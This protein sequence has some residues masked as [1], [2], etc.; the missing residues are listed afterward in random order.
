MINSVESEKQFIYSALPV[1][2][3]QRRLLSLIKR[4]LLYS[5]LSEIFE[6]STGTNR[7]EKELIEL[8]EELVDDETKSPENSEGTQ[9]K[10]KILKQSSLFD[11]KAVNHLTESVVQEMRNILQKLYWLLSTV[12]RLSALHDIYIP[13]KAPEEYKKLKMQNIITFVTEFENPQDH[14]GIKQSTL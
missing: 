14:Y 4:S 5:D 11:E 13:P 10:K 12:L 7:S 8:F 1:K 6:Y 3:S 9:K 2:S